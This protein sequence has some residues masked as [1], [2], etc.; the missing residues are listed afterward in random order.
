MFVPNFVSFATV[1]GFFVAIIFA[2]LNTNTADGLLTYILLVTI[3]FYLFSHL[4]AAFYY[5]TLNI[6]SFAFTKNNY[7]TNLDKIVGEINKR[8][9]IMKS[10]YKISDVATN[11]E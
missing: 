3:F 4:A 2:L 5:R 6:N 9:R 1:Q 7:E 10:I 8:E 11:N